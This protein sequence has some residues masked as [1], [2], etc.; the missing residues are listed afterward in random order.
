MVFGAGKGKALGSVVPQVF[1][2]APG[3]AR[4]VDKG[5]ARL[6]Q[7]GSETLND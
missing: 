5:M 4:L 7:L 3:R 1:A 2:L 6:M